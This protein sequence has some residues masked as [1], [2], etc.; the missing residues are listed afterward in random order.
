M[1]IDK[2]CH[3][4]TSLCDSL[5]QLDRVLRLGRYRFERLQIISNTKSWLFVDLR[6]GVL[7][8]SDD[9][10]ILRDKDR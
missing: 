2:L 1:V 9:M 5:F 3:K 7:F 8:A 10:T 4:A 6:Y